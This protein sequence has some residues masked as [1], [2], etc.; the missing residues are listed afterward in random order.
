VFVN[1]AGG[2]DDLV[3]DGHSF[4]ANADGAVVQRLAGFAP[5]LQ[6]VDLDA[7][8]APLDAPRWERPALIL[9][10]VVLGLRDYMRKC[11][12]TDC[13][14]GLSG[15]V[16]SALACYIAARAAGPEHVHGLLMP[17][18]YSSAHSVA[19]ARQLALALGVDHQVIP[20]DDVH[21]AYEG[22]PVVGDELRNQPAWRLPRGT[23]ASW[24]SATARCTATC[25]AAS[26]C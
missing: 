20:I 11:G 7:L 2:N 16:D 1:Q 26:P 19:D 5:D 21:S 3:F 14:L 9:D 24:R 12:F 10:A 13:V 4:V 15:G 17:S 25:A 23:R 22:L 6:L 8:P 18:R